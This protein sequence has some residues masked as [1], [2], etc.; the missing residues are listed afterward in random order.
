MPLTRDQIIALWNVRA[1]YVE[2]A[3]GT[4]SLCQ[5]NNYSLRYVLF[6]HSKGCKV[7]VD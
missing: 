2:W 1:L 6:L 4:D 3:D 5:E 7:Y